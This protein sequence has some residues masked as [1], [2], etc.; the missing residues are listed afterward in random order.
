MCKAFGKPCLELMVIIINIVKSR[1]DF[2]G[3][4]VI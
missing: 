4:L 3:M 1:Q 2:N